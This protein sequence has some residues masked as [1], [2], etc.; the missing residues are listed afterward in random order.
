MSSASGYS[1]KNMTDGPRRNNECAYV[2]ELNFHSS[3]SAANRYGKFDGDERTI[4]SANHLI[5]IELM[6]EFRRIR[7]TALG[8]ARIRLRRD[9]HKLYANRRCGIDFCHTE[10]LSTV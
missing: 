10:Q 3:T 9:P 6:H 8:C 7:K 5:T 1:R 4:I 2:D